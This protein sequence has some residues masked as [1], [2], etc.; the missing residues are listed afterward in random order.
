MPWSQH[1]YP[2]CTCLWCSLTTCLVGTQFYDIQGSECNLT[3]YPGWNAVGMQFYDM[4]WSGRSFTTFPGRDAVL[5]HAL[6]ET[7]FYDMPYSGLVGLTVSKPDR[8]LVKEISSEEWSHNI[9][10][11]LVDWFYP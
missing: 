10:W 2:T 4:T 5:R 11:L 1:S 6:V 9:E 8:S 7:Q 3:T